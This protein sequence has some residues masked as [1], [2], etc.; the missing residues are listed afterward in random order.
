MTSSASGGGGGVVQ[1]VVVV[2][3]LEVVGA[4]LI[5]NIF[6]GDDD[7]NTYKLLHLSSKHNAEQWNGGVVLV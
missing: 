7:S 2:F 6:G 4:G 3:H 5:L 1:H